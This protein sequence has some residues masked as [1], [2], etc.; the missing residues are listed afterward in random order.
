MKSVLLILVYLCIA[1]LSYSFKCGH[2]NLFKNKTIKSI[3]T[4]K[5]KKTLRNL[6]SSYEPIN[7]YVDYSSL[8]V[9]NLVGNTYIS[10]I[11]SAITQATNHFKK[12]LKVNNVYK[13]EIDEPTQCEKTLLKSKSITVD[14]DIVIY[15][16]IL[17]K[18]DLGE[19]VIAA[20]SACF[21]DSDTGRPIAGVLY[22]GASYD[23]SKVNSADYLEMVLLHE[24]SH[25]LVF[26]S[27]LFDYFPN[28]PVYK[29]QIVN[30]V[31][32]KLINSTA[33]LKMARQHFGC[34]SL[35]GLELEDQGGVGSVGSHWESRIMLG[36]YMIST[37]YDETVISDITL[38]LFEDSGWY[39]VSYYSGGL[40]RFGKDQGCSFLNEKCVKDG[41]VT[42]SKEFCNQPNEGKCLPGH[43]SK[44]ICY[45]VEYTEPLPS[46]YRYFAKS[47]QGGFFPADYCPVAIAY[48][49]D[50]YYYASSCR[51]GKK[52]QYPS[53][54]EEVIGESSI[55]IESSLTKKNDAS[56]SYYKNTFRSICHAVKCNTEKQEIII[57]IGSTSV[58][59]PRGTETVTVDGYDG[60]IKCPDYA[61]ICGSTVWCNDPL[62]CINKKSAS[63]I[64]GD[65]INSSSNLLLSPSTI[66]IIIALV[67]SYI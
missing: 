12:L 3:D 51:Y 36:D 13:I 37:D 10:N 56:L 58:S 47:T 60:K 53:G 42:F 35:S 44:G 14:A 45:I 39:Q 28:Q 16:V 19:N 22:L 27:G 9:Y 4:R 31:E 25:I 61:R 50:N 5:T 62:D 54:L 48:S 20:A 67:L 23:F 29:K 46:E 52:G 26:S 18:N 41:V 2:D 38:A 30:G 8:N 40:F 66:F 49:A 64:V 43:I 21:L 59:C 55:C 57:T 1:Q 11:K 7:F 17:S 32:R 33:V 63:S 15:P 24:I 65:K 34:D 6:A